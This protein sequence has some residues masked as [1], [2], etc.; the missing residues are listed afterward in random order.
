MEKVRISIVSTQ[1][2]PDA[3][4]DGDGVEFVTEGDYSYGAGRATLSYMESELTGLAGTRTVL[5]VESG[6]AE[7]AREGA[8]QAKMLFEE[9]RKHTFVYN[10]EYGALFLGM[11][12]KRIENGLGPEGGILEIRYVLDMDSVPLSRNTF[13]I[14]VKKV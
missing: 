8:V 7:L 11:D 2:L 10:T 4:E 9:G 5:S 3:E 6:L 1:F 14:E 12:T 13:K